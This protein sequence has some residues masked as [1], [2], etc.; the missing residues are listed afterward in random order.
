METRV[1]KIMDTMEDEEAF[2]VCGESEIVNERGEKIAT[3][4]KLC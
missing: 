1:A 3:I 4:Y 2:E